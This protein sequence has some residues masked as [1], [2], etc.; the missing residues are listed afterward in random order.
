MGKL[1]P[2]LLVAVLAVGSIPV[3]LALGASPTPPLVTTQAATNISATGAVLNGTINP[4]GQQTDYAF[5]WGPTN[6]YGHETDITAAGSS[7]STA[8]SVRLWPH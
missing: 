4:E 6:R 3:A 1:R 8:W 7:T 2:L 5:Q